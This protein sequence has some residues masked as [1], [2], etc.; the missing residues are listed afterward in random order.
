MPW[1]T[2]LPSWPLT[3]AGTWDWLI[4]WRCVSTCNNTHVA[5]YCTHA[6][7]RMATVYVDVWQYACGT[8]MHIDMVTGGEHAHECSV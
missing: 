3:S 8:V 6:M 2:G 7:W 1:C 5:L 4:L